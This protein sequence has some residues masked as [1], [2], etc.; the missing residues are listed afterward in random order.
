MTE[1]SYQQGRVF[2]RKVNYLRG[3]ITEAKGNVAK[4]T[5]IQDVHRQNGAEAQAEGTQKILNKAIKRLYDL[6]L[7]FEGMSFPDSNIMIVKKKTVQCEGCGANIA[8]GNTYCGE[9]LV[10]D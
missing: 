8:E 10:E 7:K 1:E 4:W 2:M 6:R 3:Q 5:K 9:C